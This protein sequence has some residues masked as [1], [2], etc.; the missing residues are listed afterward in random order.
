MFTVLGQQGRKADL[1]GI[2]V[3]AYYVSECTAGVMCV[4]D[5]KAFLVHSEFWTAEDVHS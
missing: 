5:I 2:V 3:A 4:V 1:S